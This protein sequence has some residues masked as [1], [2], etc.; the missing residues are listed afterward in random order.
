MVFL[1][2]ILEVEVTGNQGHFET[3]QELLF[4]DGRVFVEGEEVQQVIV[5]VLPYLGLGNFFASAPLLQL[6]LLL[7][8]LIILLQEIVV[9]HE[10]GVLYF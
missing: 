3:F 5:D 9:E 7:E 8:F 2:Q 6:Q 10:L 4:G 1:L